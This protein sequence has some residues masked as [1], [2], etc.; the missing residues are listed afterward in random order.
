MEQETTYKPEEPEMLYPDLAYNLER[1]QLEFLN[2]S[3]IMY[4]NCSIGGLNRATLIYVDGMCDVQAVDEFVLQPLIEHFRRSSMVDEGRAVELKGIF[5]PTLKIRIVYQTKEVIKAVLRG[6]TAIFTEGNAF[7][8]LAD[9]IKME[10]RAIEEATS[11]K[12]VRGPR[13]A[14]MET[15]RTNTS[16]LRR[17]LR[18]SK[19]KLESM[20]LGSI[21]E[22]DIVIGYMEG[23]VKESL[24][25]EVRARLQ[26]IQIDG[27]IHS[28]NIE[29]FIEDDVFSPFPQIQNTERPDVAVSSLLEGKVIIITDNTPFVLIVP[30]TYWSGLQAA[31]DYTDRFM[32]A[33]FVRWIR[34]TFVHT[35]L[36]LPSLYVAL[37]TF[38]LQVIPTPLVV[39]IASAREGV[40]LPAV[41]EALIMEFIFEGL[42]EAGLRLPQ[43]VG[44]AVSIAGALVIGQA[45]VAAGIISTPMVIIV[46]LT[47]I[48]S[49]AFP[50]YNLGAAYRML[51]FPL[52]VAAGILGFYGIV[53]FLIAL[54]VHMVTLKPFG[55]PYMAPYAPMST[56]NL[57]DVLVRAPKPRM[58]KLLPWL[59][60]GKSERF[61]KRTK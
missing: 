30:M 18:S 6:E 20:T 53:L 46:S 25:K 16:L 48:A 54:S 1:M 58:R 27:I 17:R 59:A 7:V 45:V 52:L 28:S 35:S 2:C 15:L 40:P 23:I 4:R 61:P 14:F 19:L 3:D 29:E 10:K 36:L 41:I 42:R 26:K 8:M 37:T 47:G 5:I 34:Y 56:G 11:E 55:V 9:L 39:S 57:N 31:D 51:R 38:H 49:F 12:V 24:V 43:Q 50:L 32:Y 33:T 13:D 44:P 22:T 60:K 21:S